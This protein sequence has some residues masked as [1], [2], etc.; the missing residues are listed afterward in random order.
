MKETLISFLE[1]VV[2]G[3]YGETKL[4][5][6]DTSN[7]W[8]CAE[9]FEIEEITDYYWEWNSLL[10]GNDEINISELEDFI[11]STIKPYN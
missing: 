8:E 11:F 10:V 2:K 1:N 4:T 9:Q 7:F 3:M 6:E 5:H